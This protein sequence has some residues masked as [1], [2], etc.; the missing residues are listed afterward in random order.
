VL[1]IQLVMAAPLLPF[2][3]PPLNGSSIAYKV[4]VIWLSFGCHVGCQYL[5][6]N[7]VGST[8]CDG[9]NSQECFSLT[10]CCSSDRPLQG[11]T[12]TW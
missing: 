10:S 5:V 1:Q 7:M 12:T 8:A 3:L 2:A 4:V 11:A 6:L 9:P